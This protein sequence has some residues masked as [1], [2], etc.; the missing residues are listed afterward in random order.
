M[1]RKTLLI[2]TIALVLLG[3][4]ILGVRGAQPIEPPGVSKGDGTA[5]IML[6]QTDGD[7]IPKAPPD[8][9]IVQL[10]DPP[11]AQ[12]RGGIQGLGA[13][14]VSATGAR[15]LQVDTPEAQAYIDYLEAEQASVATAVEEAV[16]GAYIEY[17]YQVV[18]NGL[19]VNLPEADTKASE[20]L[21]ELPGVEAV[22]RQKVYRPD[23]YASLPL[24]DAPTLWGEVGGQADAGKGIKVAS[25]DS[26][27][28]P[29]NP[30]FDPADYSYPTGY[31]LFDAD[32]PHMN[33]EKVIVARAYFRDEDPPVVGDE[34]TWPGDEG[35]SH[36]THTS[37]I[38]ACVPGTVA[39]VDG[40]SYT[41]SG[42]AP[43]AYLMS[44]KVFYPT[45]SEWAGSAFDPELIAAVEDAVYDGA[46]VVNNSWGEG[47][48]SSY[49]DALDLAYEAA[50]D[51]GVVVVFSAGNSGPYPYTVDHESEKNILV[52]ASTTT[53]TIA[54]GLFDVTAPPTVPMTLTS[55]PMG[56]CLF[57]P[58]FSGLTVGPEPLLY[59]ANVTVGSTD[60]LCN[61]ETV[62]PTTAFSGTIAL[63][64][65]GGC[66]FSDKVWNA[67]EAGATAAIIYNNAGDEIINMAQGSHED[68]TFTIP[69]GFIGQTDGE[70]VVDWSEAHP[71]TAEGQLDYTPRQ[72]GNI[73]D[74]L[75]S[76]S[77]RGPSLREKMDPDVVAPGVN[78]LSA[79][80]GGG[81][82]ETS[83]LGFGQVSGTSMSAPHV[84]GAAAVL[85]QLYPHWT[86]AQ[87]KSALM[88]TAELDL[89]DYDGTD[90]GVLDRG[91]GRIDLGEAWDPG[92]TF[93]RPSLSFDHIFAGESDTRTVMATDV[94]AREKGTTFTYNLTISETG[95]LT[96]TGYF[97][98][99]VAPMNVTFEDDGDTASFDVS[100]EIAAEAPAGDYEGTV[101]LRHGP[102]ELHVPVWIHVW[103]EASENPVLLIDNDFSDLLGFPDYTEHYTSALESLGIGYDYY[104]ADLHF[105]SERT[106]PP[107]S[108][109]Q[110]YEAVIWYTGDNFYPDGSFSVSTPPT[111]WDQDV[112]I[113]YLQSGGRLLATGQDLASAAGSLE[114]D[115]APTGLYNYFLGA[116]YVQDNV[117]TT[118]N[119]LLRTVYGY[120]WASDL[121]LD[122]SFSTTVTQPT[123]INGAANQAWVDEVAIYPEAGP[124]ERAVPADPIFRADPVDGII[125]DEG[126]VGL[127]RVAEETLEEPTKLFEGRTVYLSF[128]FE[129][130]NNPSETRPTVDSREDVLAEL[131][132]FLFTEP[133]VSLPD[134]MDLAVGREMTFV[135]E[136]GW[137]L[138]GPYHTADIVQYRWDFGDGSPF[139]TTAVPT[140]S[141]I[142]DEPGTYTLRVEVTDEFG[143]KGLDE[144][145]VGADVTLYMPFVAKN[146]ILRGARLTLLHNND[147]ESE[148][149]PGDDNFGGV[150][151]FASVVE[152][153]RTEVGNVHPLLL[154]TSGDNFLAGPEWTASVE[155]GVPFYDSIALDLIGY[156]AMALGNH[157]FDFGPDTLANFIEGFTMSEVPFVSANLDFSAEP[158]LAA[159]V[160]AGRISGSVIVEDEGERFGIVGATTPNLTFISS[161]R[162]VEVGQ[163]VQAAVQTEINALEAAGVN[164][165][166]LI[167][168]LQGIAEDMALAP[169]LSGLDVMVA[170]G[171]DELLA[172]DDDLLIPGDE[173]EIHGPYPMV[174]QNADGGDV[175]VVTTSG[176]YEYLGRLEV[177]FDAEGRV[178][179]FTGGPIRVAGGDLPDAVQPDAA[180]EEQVVD[181]VAAFVEDLD[182]NVLATSEVLLDGRRNEIRSRETNEGDLITDS[183]LWKADDLHADFGAPAPDIA[184]ANGGGIRNDSIIPAG[185]VTELD[186]FD[187]LPF[188]NFLTIVPG[189][190]P[191][192]FEALLENAVS[193]IN[194]AGEP[195]GEGTGRFA[196]IAGFSFTYDSTLSAGSRVMSATLGDGTV[197]IEG[198][199]IAPTARDVNIVVVDFLA[200]GGDE[201]FGGPPGRDD[202][203][204]LGTSYQQALADYL[205][206]S[207]AEGGLGGTISASAYP[208]G[209]EGRIVNLAIS[210]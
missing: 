172:N 142:Y 30:C 186:T 170:G 82:G 173:S 126:Y 118:T 48:G 3:V 187:M 128:G 19:T 66:A 98:L 40:V 16:P 36:G 60:T 102:H 146:G 166:I 192:E 148:L 97:T 9:W 109:L 2:T 134:S 115:S 71:A 32:K 72:I 132:T 28:H 6:P 24:I 196:Q 12:Y 108:T 113:G 198:G 5:P 33:T 141:H 94:F 121:K 77:S 89:V 87:I 13:T 91:A 43:A 131:L 197:M 20:W 70:N 63:I 1:V 86:P 137:V 139:R 58:S 29:E 47:S 114:N 117:F 199:A 93:N 88:G 35:S 112:L 84:S 160:T 51:A 75:A 101:W 21:S 135:A 90:V 185:P 179:S 138:T 62:S 209:G 81:A 210:P 7:D 31:P 130:I 100:V 111:E 11:L 124:D 202:F 195:E 14:A 37:G 73:P 164:K 129:G 8:R 22:F 158:T 17:D 145:S 155:K 96:T 159:L 42:V 163:D 18:F 136:A 189:V 23:L 92:L 26:G 41:I 176:E 76:F 165:I 161:P 153:V 200:R 120:S 99:G 152:Q 156:E 44:Y 46:D 125:E 59:A 123:W 53:G 193:R 83:H 127:A 177:S 204:I 194:V 119:P 206:T 68:D 203:I 154:V 162:N 34:G 149:L 107:A 175:P 69:A 106:F 27:I 79:G 25:I 122:L 116:D 39:S 45:D 144:S 49:A 174:V 180:V 57:C 201:Y 4:A 207:T 10:E 171:G 150:A 168:H 105:G 50:W 55:I 182:E 61:G 183:F 151:H 191:A 133:T 143:H 190:T 110:Q 80:Y 65:R 54:S 95:N 38:V 181:P 74:R 52:G 178:V 169:Q 205:E 208:Q 167:S 56:Q 147:G 184:M 188:P 78:I 15:R 140:I 67:Q 103:S 64:K 157:D 104:N 85:K